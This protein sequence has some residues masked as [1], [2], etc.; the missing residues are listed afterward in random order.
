[1]SWAIAEKDRLFSELKPH[2]GRKWIFDTR[3]QARQAKKDWGLD[4]RIY[5]IVKIKIELA[6]DKLKEEE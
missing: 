4:F 6:P 2:R 1:M 5:R 3:Q